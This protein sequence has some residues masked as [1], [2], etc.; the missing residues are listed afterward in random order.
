MS[1]PIPSTLHQRS[2]GYTQ[3]LPGYIAE[4]SPPLSSASSIS[5]SSETETNHKSTRKSRLERPR[6]AERQRSS[7]IIIPKTVDTYQ[8][9]RPDYPPD[10][11]IAMSPRRSSEDLE[12]LELGIRKSLQEYFVP[13]AFVDYCR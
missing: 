12:R 9:E 5:S 2:T 11:A 7:S 3:D 10:D 1:A 4:E 8:S 13:R 6:M